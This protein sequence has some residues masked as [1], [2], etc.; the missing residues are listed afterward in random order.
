MEN[1]KKKAILFLHGFTQNS[2]VFETRLKVLIKSIKKELPEYTILIPDAPFVL[3][4]V[5]NNRAWM[6]LNEENK[7]NS[8][9]FKNKE[10]VYKGL[11]TSIECIGKLCEGYDIQCVFG[12]SQGSLLAIF[13]MII[14]HT[15]DI[16][17]FSDLKC[18]VL[19]AGFINPI[20]LNEELNKYVDNCLNNNDYSNKISIPTLHVYGEADEYIPASKS[21]KALVLFKDP[22]T[23]VH[24]GKHCVP[25]TKGDVEKF[26]GYL[27]KYL[28]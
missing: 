18:V 9:E 11:S 12:F 7:M 6:Y 20:P 25:S 1:N 14:L 2:V 19:V 23:Y 15:K 13:L 3:D 27:K 21:E 5:N 17:L 26:L 22:E 16:G 10:V 24:K 4:E 8:E 28:S